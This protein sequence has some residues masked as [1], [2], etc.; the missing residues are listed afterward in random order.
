MDW[1]QRNSDRLEDQPMRRTRTLVAA[2]SLAVA[3]TL[4]VV[5]C[6]S[7]VTPPKASSTA[8]ASA[9]A[10]HQPLSLATTPA[11]KPLVG[12]NLYV[13]RNYSLAQTKDFGARDLKY[14]AHDLK[15]KAVS[16]AWDYNVPSR[17]SNVVN[18]SPTRTPTIADLA[19]LTSIAKSYGMRVEYRVLYA[20]GNSDS[21]GTSIQ[22]KNLS[23]WLRSL[24]AT[25]TPALK[26]AQRD[27]VSEFIAGTEMASIDQSPLWGGFFAKAGRDYH[28]IL[29]YASWGGGASPGGFFS[30]RRVLLPLKYFGASAYP[31]INLPPTASVAQLKKAWVAFLR[32]APESLL[33]VTALDE[34]GI[35]EVAGA[36]KDP[37][38]WSGLGDAKP[39]PA[40]QANW[41]KAACQAADL[42]HVRAIYFWSAVLSSDPAN[43]RPSLVGFEDHPAT[44]AAI[45]SCS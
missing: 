18:D 9:A 24:L 23:A 32:K 45:R 39:D 21:R 42:V 6:T 41:Y 40:I 30:S 3:A 19:A 8:A 7:A 31:P 43:A 5:A 12:V 20:L 11:P 17:T 4:G 28:G 27:H 25:E 14:F 29:S 33:H 22:P 37:Y 44:E 16:I 38:Q 2:S 35:P 26:L 1:F 10:Q 34:L 13:N 15:L 36:Y